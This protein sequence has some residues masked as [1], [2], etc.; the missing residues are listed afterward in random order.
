MSSP[1]LKEGK[2]GECCPDVVF[3]VRGTWQANLLFRH[4]CGDVDA[5][6]LVA[7]SPGASLTRRHAATQRTVCAMGW[8]AQLVAQ[9]FSFFGC[10]RM[11][12]D[13]QKYYLTWEVRTPTYTCEHHSLDWGSSARRFKSCQPDTGQRHFPDNRD[14]PFSIRTTTRTPTRGRS[15]MFAGDKFGPV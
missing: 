2:H 5:G 8:V 6:R 9:R 11:A 3:A 14:V 10:P 4:P 7:K 1:A 15:S 12:A 13:V